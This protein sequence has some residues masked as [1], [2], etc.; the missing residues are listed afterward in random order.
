MCLRHANTFTSSL[1]DVN[2]DV[3]RHNPPVIL[4]ILLLESQSDLIIFKVEKPHLSH[5]VLPAFLDVL[6][7]PSGII[8]FYFCMN[9]FHQ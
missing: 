2:S 6:E 9:Y 5:F 8:W 7:I 4:G 3:I 1:Q